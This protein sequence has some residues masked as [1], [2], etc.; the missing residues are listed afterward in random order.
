M[1]P[2]YTFVI[3]Y[4][5]SIGI[6]LLTYSKYAHKTELKVF[7]GFLIY[8]FLTELMGA[9]LGRVLVVNNN[10]VYNIWNIINFFFYAYFVLSRLS[11]RKKRLF[12]YFLIGI[13]FIVTFINVVFYAGI[14]RWVLVKN[15]IFA[16]TLVAIMI[17]VYLIELLQSDEILNFKKSLFFW[18]CVGVF[19]MNLVQLPVLKLT[20]FISFEGAY[21][22]IILGLNIIMHLCFIT[23]FI[24]SKKEYN[25]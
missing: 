23:G 7:L 19:L 24:V 14:T 17:I 13:F 15:S 16:K 8:S 25:N 12:I 11:E 18:V 6:G 10:Y 4:G 5:V 22:Y 20:Y 21:R 9:Y 3:I 2:T 1:L